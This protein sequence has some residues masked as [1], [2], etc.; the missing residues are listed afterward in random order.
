MDGGDDIECE[1][2][3]R[4]DDEPSRVVRR[5]GICPDFTLIDFADITA[6][7]D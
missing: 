1:P 2:S 4:C 5:I 3:A 7:F 6:V